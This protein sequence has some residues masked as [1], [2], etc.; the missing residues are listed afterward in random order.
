MT[1]WSVVGN[2]M[3]WSFQKICNGLS[4]FPL[5]ESSLSIYFRVHVCLPSAISDMGPLLV[6][7][8]PEVPGESASFNSSKQIDSGL[9]KAPLWWHKTNNTQLSGLMQPIRLQDMLRRIEIRERIRKRQTERLCVREQ[10]VEREGGR[11]TDRQTGRRTG[12]V[13][14]QHIERSKP[15]WRTDD[16]RWER[17]YVWERSSRYIRLLLKLKFIQGR[18]QTPSYFYS[19]RMQ[20]DRF[21]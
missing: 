16:A 20:T 6:T 18:I 4:V 11:P 1:Q 2:Q 15:T 3:W 19:R 13:A 14:E 17:V 12:E 7:R 5:C 10:R 21:R 8:R 9:A